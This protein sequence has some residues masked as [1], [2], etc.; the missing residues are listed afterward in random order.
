[1]L[2]YERPDNPELSFPPSIT[3]DGRYI[4]L[5]V[6]HAAISRN[7]FYYRGVEEEEAFVRLID[8]PDAF[9]NFVGNDGSTFYLHTDLEAPNGR[10]IAI[11]LGQPG[12]EYWR[13]LIPEQADPID[14]VRMVNNQFVVLTMH[15]A[16]HQ[17]KLHD[18]NGAAAGQVPLPLLGS[19]INLTG[20]RQDQELFFNF[21]SF[22]YPST[23]FRY[24]FQSKKVTSFQEPVVDFD[25]GGYE[26]RQVF[27]ESKDGTQV[28]MFLTHRKELALDGR[29]PTLLYGYGGFN[30][31][32]T[33]SFTASTLQWLERG[34]VYALANLRGGNEYGE[35]WHE[36]GML[37]KKQNVFDDFISAAEWLIENGYTKAS[38][39]GIMGRSNGGLLVAAA[40]L[41][42][43]DLFGAVICAV[44]V[45]DMLRFHKFT[46]GRYWTAEYGNAEEPEQFPFLYAYSPLHNVKKGTPYPPTLITT[47]ETD[48]RVVPMHA[49]KFA[50]TLQAA[51]SNPASGPILL[52]V[53]TRAGHGLGKPTRKVID[54]FTDIYAFLWQ[55]L[56]DEPDG[57]VHR[58][59]ARGE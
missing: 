3:E 34:G 18:L 47:A 33:P 19:V 56:G 50:A 12:R 11:D 15:N 8:E 32:L 37:E 5:H 29:N 10:V 1:V 58:P 2:I 54:E 39:L 31:S 45:T 40:L 30:I 9:Y 48:D 55:M 41:Q 44:P 16:T 21:D 26:T 35:S 4:V 57:P 36:A 52:R 43:P 7:R 49:G 13:T 59:A 24:D 27:Y 17:I 14:S 25:P 28:S 20:R 23:P 51:A 38:R 6:W 22:L 46:A 42:R 53:E